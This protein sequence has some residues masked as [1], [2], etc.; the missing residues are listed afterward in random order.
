M[1]SILCKV[2]DCIFKKSVNESSHRIVYLVMAIKEIHDGNWHD[3]YTMSYI[4]TI[5]PYDE[6]LDDEHLDEEYLV[7]HW[8]MGMVE[9]ILNFEPVSMAPLFK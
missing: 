2:G 5:R 6:H 8:V 7:A 3:G 9:P 1:D 4:A